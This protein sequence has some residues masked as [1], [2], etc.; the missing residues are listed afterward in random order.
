M[1]KYHFDGT[2]PKDKKTVFVFGSNLSGIHG[3]GAAL[4]AKNNFGAVKSVVEGISGRSYA[5]P[6]KNRILNTLPLSVIRASVEKFLFYAEMHKE[7][8]FFVTRVGCG[9]AGYREEDIASMFRS[10]GENCS[11]SFNWKGYLE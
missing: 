3:A 10:A 11:F 2:T 1:I 4:E 5:I 8:E 6:T 7:T 9:L